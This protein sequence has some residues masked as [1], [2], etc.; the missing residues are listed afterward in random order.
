MNV[1]TLKI[2]NQLG[3]DHF[4]IG[5][6]LDADGHGIDLGN[7]RRAIPPRPKDDLEALFGERTHQ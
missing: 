4:R 1:G 3:L 5:H 6:V 2:F 7:M